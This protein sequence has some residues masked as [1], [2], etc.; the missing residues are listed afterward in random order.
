MIDILQIKVKAI[1]SDAGG[2]YIGCMMGK[3]NHQLVLFNSRQT[4]ATLASP[5]QYILDYGPGVVRQHIE[6]S[7]LRFIVDGS[8]AAAP[9]PS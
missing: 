7:N 9:M 2:I 6:R 8:Q 4:G 5:L 1:V 3:D